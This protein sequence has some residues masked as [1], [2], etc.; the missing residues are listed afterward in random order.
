[1]PRPAN[2]ACYVTRGARSRWRVAFR[3]GIM[4]CMSDR[5]APR[6]AWL[7]DVDGTLLSTEGTSTESF[8]HAL[9]VMRGIEPDL[10]GLSLAGRLDPL[11][12]ADLLERCGVRFE[13]GQAG[14]FWDLVYARARELLVPPRGRLMPGIPDVIDAVRAATPALV[15]LLTGNMAPMAEIKLRRFGIADRFAFGAYGDMAG[16]RDE[17]A[18][19]TVA[20]LGREHGI[21]REC[22]IVVGDTEHDIACARAAGARVVSVATGARR[23]EVL[24]RYAPDLLLDDL[25][26]PAP[27]IDWVRREVDAR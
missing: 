9:R 23:R 18:R 2:A 5:E 15:G 16:S 20:R 7:F 25:S 12:L 6:I 1:M 27:L 8:L 13:D 11:I 24:E 3:T 14:R 4:P 21:P 17:L 22:C 19:L 26:D 10:T